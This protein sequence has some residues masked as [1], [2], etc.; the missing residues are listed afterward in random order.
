MKFLLSALLAIA[1]VGCA[2]PT[3]YE[4]ITKYNNENGPK[5]ATGEI[6]RTVYYQELLSLI[7][8]TPDSS[9]VK[10]PDIRYFSQLIPL[11]R[12][13][14]SGELTKDQFDDKKRNLYLQYQVDRKQ[15]LRDEDD[16]DRTIN[17]QAY[18]ALA[19]MKQSQA[20]NPAPQLP[21]PYMLP[22][23]Q[24]T[25]CTSTVYGNQVNTNCR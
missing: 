4:A 17:L 10:I 3:P 15:A 9:P 24:G 6:K 19:Q 21:L 22:T 23:N 5:I 8:K 18:G 13:L 11:A 1:L 16:R 2:A 7:Y 20:A 25:N 14:E 12:Q